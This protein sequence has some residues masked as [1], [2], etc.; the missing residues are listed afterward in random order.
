MKSREGDFVEKIMVSGQGKSLEY[1]TNATIDIVKVI[2][3]ILVIGIHTE[4]FGFNIWLDRGFAIITR[5]CVPFFFITSSYFYW[6]KDKG[7]LKFLKRIFLLYLIWSLIYLPFDIHFLSEKTIGDILYFHFWEG[8]RHALWYLWG[9]IVGFIITYLSLKIFKPK[10]VLIISV[11]FL[12]IGCLK[13][14]W[15]PLIENIFS[16]NI[17]D[18]FG[19]RNGLFYAFPYFSLGMV[20]AKS[21]DKGK[22]RN[23]K[24]LITGFLVSFVFLIIESIICILF[25]KSPSTIMWISC[26]PYSYFLFMIVNNINIHLNKKTSLMLRKISTL[27]YVSQYL[28]IYMFEFFGFHGMILFF[29]VSI[30]TLIFAIIIIKLSE[31]KYFKCLKYLY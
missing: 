25:F 10:T 9:S 11:F 20:I 1:N 29:L 27:M 4:P 23:V 31:F 6:L 8:N 18:L 7:A 24:K 26:F 30:S 12:L 15:S 22:N 5:L 14:T 3:A 28:F 21:H 17:T 16:C 13:S 2:M 19:S